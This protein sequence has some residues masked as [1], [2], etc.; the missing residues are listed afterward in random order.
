MAVCVATAREGKLIERFRGAL[1]DDLPLTLMCQQLGRRVRFRRQSLLATPVQFTFGEFFQF[2]RRQYILIRVY[3]P[4]LYLFA[5]G[6]TSLYVVGFVSAWATLVAQWF[7]P[8]N[9]TF[10]L[11]PA[12][13]VLIVLAANHYRA[14]MRQVLVQRAFGDQVLEQLRSTLR[15]DRWATIVWMSLHFFVVVSAALGRRVRWRSVE[16]RLLGPQNVLRL[17]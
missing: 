13:I 3:T 1:T 16:Y 5:L 14:S 2:A 7:M 15:Y 10:W 9:D 17:N 8:I 11:Y 12:G 4:L 6:L